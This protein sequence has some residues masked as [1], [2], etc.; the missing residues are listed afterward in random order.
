[1]QKAEDRKQPSAFCL[2]IPCDHPIIHYHPPLLHFLQKNIILL[3]TVRHSASPAQNLRADDLSVTAEFSRITLNLQLVTDQWVLTR[4]P[5]DSPIEITIDLPGYWYG[6]QQWPLNK[7]M[8][9]SA[10]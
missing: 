7:I 5:I 10:A 9:Q 4:A 6:N 8:L 3:M 2:L 1:L